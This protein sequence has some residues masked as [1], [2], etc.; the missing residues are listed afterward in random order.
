VVTAGTAAGAL[1]GAVGV[2]QLGVQFRA[3]LT[4]EGEPPPGA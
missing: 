4:A 3:A 1:L 2:A